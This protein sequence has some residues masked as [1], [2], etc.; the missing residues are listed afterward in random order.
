MILISGKRKLDLDMPQKQSVSTRFSHLA[1]EKLELVAMQKELLKY[2]VLEA[3]E[4]LEHNRALRAMEM[5]D[6]KKAYAHKDV[7]RALELKEF[8]K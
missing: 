2:Q 1:S 4:K 3:Q 8:Q 7:I 5:E 6:A